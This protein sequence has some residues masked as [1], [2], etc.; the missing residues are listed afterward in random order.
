M[1][2]GKIFARLRGFISRNKVAFGILVIAILLRVIGYFLIDKEA[3]IISPTA[4][5]LRILGYVFLS[6]AFVVLFGRNKRIFLTNIAVLFALVFLFEGV[7]YFLLGSPIKEYKLFELAELEEGHIAEALGFVPYADSTISECKVIDGDTIFNVSSTIG[8][9]CERLTPDHD[10]SKTKYALFFGCSIAFGYGLNDNET[11]PY[12]YQEETGANSYNFAFSGY[13]T[14]MMLARLQYQNLREYIPKK[15]KVGAAYYVFYWDHIER[16]IGS[17]ARHTQWMH[18]SPNYEFQNGKLVRNKL[19]KNGRPLRSW[20]YENFYQSS[21][22]K[23]FDFTFPA[24]LND[25]HFDLVSEMILE[26]KREYERQFGN[27]NFYLIIYPTYEELDPEMV[28]SFHGYLKKKGITII[29]LNENFKF[30]PANSIHSEHEP[31]PSAAA[32]HEI[33]KALRERIR[34]LNPALV[35]P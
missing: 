24:R 15:E 26:S 18:Y 13:G 6:I 19:F 2:K 7:C 16:A 27:D 1:N 9:D 8:H 29:D 35:E 4:N 5:Y 28:K 11:F 12:F 32:N 3:G 30:G 17:M 10:S 14:Q 20:F 31:H 21:I 22:L 34:A 25:E 33:A 23:Y